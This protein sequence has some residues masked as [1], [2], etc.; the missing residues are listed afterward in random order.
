MIMLELCA[1]KQ[2]SN[3]TCVLWYFDTYRIFDCP[4]RGQSVRVS[5]D[6]AGSLNKMLRISRVSSLKNQFNPSKHLA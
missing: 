4:H 6:A 3:Y 5:S 1:V 2:V